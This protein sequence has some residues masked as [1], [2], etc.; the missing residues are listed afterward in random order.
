MK[1]LFSVCLLLFSILFSTLAYSQMSG[2]K[3]IPVDYPTIASAIAALNTQ[4]VGNGGIVFNVMA[5]HTENSSN[6]LISIS[7]NQPTSANPITFQ[8][9]GSGV[10]PTIFANPGTS[11]SLDGII[12]LSGTDYITFDGINLN[13][14]N[15]S[16][17]NHLM[18]WGFALMRASTNDGC[19]NVVIRNCG[20]KLQKVNTASIGIYVTN[21]D[22][23]GNEITAAN[24][25]AQNN[26]N[27]FYGNNITGA[28]KGIVV[29]STSTHRDIDNEI[30]VPDETANSITNWGGGNVSSDGIRCEG[31]INIKIRNNK[32][33]GGTGTTNAVNGIIADLFGVSGLASSYEISYNEVSVE[34]GASTSATYGIRALATGDTVRIHNNT[35]QNCTNLHTASNFFGIIH[36]P[37]DTTSAAYIN[38]NVVRNNTHPGTGNATILGS[39]GTIKMLLIRS[40]QIYNNQK[41]GTSGTMTCISAANGFVE[42]DSNLIHD[43]SIPSTSGTVVSILYG[44][45]NNASPMVESVHNNTIYNLSIGGTGTSASIH[46]SGIRSLVNP[47]A[48]KSFYENLIY[49]I[50]SI[51]GTFFPGGAF[52]ILSTSGTDTKI[53][54]NRI[55]NISNFGTLGTTFGIYVTAGS[56]ISIFN[57]FVSD[58]EAPNSYSSNAVTGISMTNPLINSFAYIYYNTVYLNTSGAFSFGSTGLMIAS[59]FVSTTSLLDLKNNII[60]N[61]STPGTVSG[62]CAA[63]RRS[64]LYLD[65]FGLSSDYN[66]FYVG[67]PSVNKLIFYDNTNSDQTIEEYKLRVA[68]RES[69]AKSFPVYFQDTA[70]ADLHLAGASVGDLNLAGIPIAGFPTDYDNEYRNNMFPYIGADEAI[71]F[72][73]PELNLSVNLEACSPNQDTIRVYLR[74]ALNPYAK[75]DSATGYLSPT[76]T[77]SLNFLN[78]VNGVNYYIVVKHRNSIETWSKAGGEAFTSGILNYDF[79]NSASQAYGSNMKL[80]GS[81]YSFYTGDVNNDG[82]V[83]G[84]DALLIDN[85]ASN[86]TTGYVVTDLNCDNSVDATDLLFA[87][88]NASNFVGII[89]P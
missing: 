17:G 20:I 40:N 8:K 67:T 49:N 81:K 89:Q 85:D 66:L 75:V 60:I 73:I 56:V 84:V 33:S 55:Y 37:T 3:V 53:H 88:N 80:V 15:T 77:V 59:S 28:Y 51:S 79:T 43:N 71:A 39:S 50:S 57:N 42:C 34:A 47:I 86:F 1:N 69:H 25:S 32:V 27:K 12:K 87:D 18:E 52:G 19:R 44:Y 48:I 45:F 68:P 82:V 16:L 36:D 72:D 61:L 83:D 2:T 24:P 5:G 64:V 62:I 23:E 9:V 38:D 30:G 78:A 46:V 54:R 63:Y 6:I 41:T 31:Q 22:K 58:I 74:N 65:N 7:S 13:D 26:Y 11:P 70:T 29:I 76:G 21:R 14:P 10:N 35:V 4:G